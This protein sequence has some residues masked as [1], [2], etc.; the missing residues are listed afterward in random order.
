MDPDQEFKAALEDYLR[1]YPETE[2]PAENDLSERL[3]LAML[4]YLEGGK[5][6]L[7]KFLQELESKEEAEDSLES[8][9]EADHNLISTT[10]QDSE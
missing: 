2:D 9:Q 10:P 1:L 8:K 4:A 7:A 6:G 3:D 5:P